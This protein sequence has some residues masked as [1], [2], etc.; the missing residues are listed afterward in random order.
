MPGYPGLGLGVKFMSEDNSNLDGVLVIDKP[1]GCTSHD[2]VSRVKKKLG[3]RKVGHLGTLDPSATGVLPL[4]INRATKEARRLEGGE[5][6]YVAL[7]TLGLETDTLDADGAVTR[8]G[9]AS[10]VTG[11][12]VLRVLNGFRG[13]IMQVPPMYSAV[14]RDGVPLYRLARK[15]VI[16]ERDAKEVEVFDI[17]VI[18]MEGP[19]EG[20]P[21]ES[22]ES[23]VASVSFRVVCSRGTY[24]RSLCADSGALLG[25]GA[26]L[27]ALRRVKSGPFTTSEAVSPG[28]TRDELLR[29][30]IPLRQ[31]LDKDKF[32]DK[33]GRGE[34]ALHRTGTDKPGS[35]GSD[36][37]TAPGGKE[38]ETACI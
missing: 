33:I 21:M 6:E 10:G 2:V 7:M 16:V 9:D 11:E 19:K 28:A 37:G 3:A 36:G 35:T 30:I 32:G 38:T 29:A 23:G 26:H 15:G 17:E 1:A 20:L 27:A 22:G 13:K 25:C 4:V 12:D 14:K 8:R 24:V 31:L 5:K 34:G 18:S